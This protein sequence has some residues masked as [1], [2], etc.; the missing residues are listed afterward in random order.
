MDYNKQIKDSHREYNLGSQRWYYK[1]MGVSKLSSMDLPNFRFILLISIC[2]LKVF[3]E[4][5]LHGQRFCGL[6]SPQPY[7]LQF[8]AVQGLIDMQQCM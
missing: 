2:A 4:Q 8:A 5:Q 7:L 3:M 1:V 6:S